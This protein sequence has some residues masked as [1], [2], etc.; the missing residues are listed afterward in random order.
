M[1]S[2]GHLLRSFFSLLGSLLQP[3]LSSAQLRSP[4][5]VVNMFMEVYG[6]GRMAE[7]LPY[8]VPAFRDGL[9]QE[10]WLERNYSALKALGNV[11]LEGIIRNGT[12]RGKRS[13][14]RGGEPDP[15]ERRLDA[16]LSLAA[17]GGGLETTR[18]LGPG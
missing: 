7:I 10:A 1:N 13:Y 9:H 17:H 6:T 2:P 12:I 8:T 16:A 15:H 4:Q 3:S 11:Q 14:S 18:P 5:D